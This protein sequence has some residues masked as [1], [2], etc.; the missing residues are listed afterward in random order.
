[1]PIT[2][3]ALRV[4]WRFRGPAAKVSGKIILIF[5]S[6][7]GIIA[8]ANFVSNSFY[9][10]IQAIVYDLKLE[11]SVSLTF[12][13]INVTFYL[14]LAVVLILRETALRGIV[15][16]AMLTSGSTQR[17]AIMMSAGLDFFAI[18]VSTLFGLL[19]RLTRLS[20]SD[21]YFLVPGLVS[22]G[23]VLI[24]APTLGWLRVSTGKLW[25]CVVVALVSAL[26]VSGIRFG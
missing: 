25:P 12:D 4:A 21:L 1:M 18:F 24:T 19:S 22:I 8:L 13:L 7:L 15:M 3:A 20:G 11:W 9:T 14:P 2:I 6:C 17:N 10:A 5:C 26:I 16:G 23:L